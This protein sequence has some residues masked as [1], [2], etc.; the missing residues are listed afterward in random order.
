MKGTVSSVVKAAA[1]VVVGVG[2]V[3]LL[4]SGEVGDV[5]QLI[6]G[7]LGFLVVISAA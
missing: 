3:E 1:A 2:D 7:Q 5:L 4:D 6:A